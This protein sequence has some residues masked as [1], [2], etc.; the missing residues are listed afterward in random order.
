MSSKE[1]EFSYGRILRLRDVQT[2]T[3]MSRSWDYAA[4]ARDAFPS[5][6]RLGERAVGWREADVLSWLS[7]RPQ[8]R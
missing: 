2:L 3:G 7:D 6:I 1:D 5:P 8:A 4:M